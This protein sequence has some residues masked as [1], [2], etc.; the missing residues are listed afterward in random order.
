M[1]QFPRTWAPWLPNLVLLGFSKLPL[2]AMPTAPSLPLGKYQLVL[3]I[4]VYTHVLLVPHQLLQAFGGQRGK[5]PLC[6]LRLCWDSLCHTSSTA[7]Q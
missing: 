3:H 1:K 2:H 6:F 4:Y 7:I 5:P